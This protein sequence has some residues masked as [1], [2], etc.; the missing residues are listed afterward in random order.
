MQNRAIC[1]AKSSQK[2]AGLDAPKL[3]WNKAR[4]LRKHTGLPKAKMLLLLLALCS[5]KKAKKT[6]CFFTHFCLQLTWFSSK[7]K[8]FV[9]VLH[10]FQSSWLPFW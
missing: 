5:L 8:P 7:I 3:F 9:I 1:E 6:S 4:I 10:T 2:R